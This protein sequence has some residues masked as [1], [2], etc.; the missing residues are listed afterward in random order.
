MELESIFSSF[1]QDLLVCLHN[2]L[3]LSNF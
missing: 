1:S 3:A 2:F